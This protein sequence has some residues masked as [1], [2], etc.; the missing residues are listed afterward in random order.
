MTTIVPLLVELLKDEHHEVKMGVLSGLQSVA[1]VV[2]AEV[3]TS[4]LLASLSALMSEAQWR[5]RMALVGMLAHF[6]KEFGKDFYAKNLESTFMQFLV[7]AV[8][9]VR[10]LGIKTLQTLAVEYKADWVVNGYL[11][12]ALEIL[13]REKQGYLYRMAVLNSTAVRHL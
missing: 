11:P 1:T 8:A 7:D 10:E 5:V 13:N 9:A 3:M 12:K 4:T 2:G 6:G